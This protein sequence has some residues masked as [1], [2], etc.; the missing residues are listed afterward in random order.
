MEKHYQV[1]SLAQLTSYV[2]LMGTAPGV[3][4]FLKVVQDYLA[5]WTVLRIRNL[6]LLDGGWGPFDQH[7]RPQP[8]RTAADVRRF[9]KS[10]SDQLRALKA[11]GIDPNSELLELD[12]FF[13]FANRTLEAH[14]PSDILG[15]SETKPDHLIASRVLGTNRLR[16]GPAYRRHA[17]S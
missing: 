5:T 17:K 1:E 10:V 11:S 14:Q 9:G 4:Q 2:G 7:L 6:Q 16:A 8:V 13:F 15:S 12:L 3:N